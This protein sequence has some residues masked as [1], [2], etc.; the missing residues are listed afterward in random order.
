MNGLIRVLELCTV[1]KKGYYVMAVW[2]IFGKIGQLWKQFYLW[3]RQRILNVIN[4]NLSLHFH[5]IF[6]LLNH[7]GVQFQW[8]N[9]S[10]STTIKLITLHK[11]LY[12]SFCLV[13]CKASENQLFWLVIIAKFLHVILIDLLLPITN[14]VCS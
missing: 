3:K 2:L 12:Y 7:L 6:I 13:S 1:L 9:L 10:E 14:V 4:N 11:V 5:N 8:K